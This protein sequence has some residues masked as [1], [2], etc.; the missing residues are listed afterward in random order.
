MNR[1]LPNAAIAVV[2][3]LLVAACVTV[4]ISERRVASRG[5][6]AA[7][8]V[9]VGKP[10]VSTPLF[11]MRRIPE[12]VSMPLVSRGLRDSLRAFDSQLPPSSCLIVE[13][14]G[15]TMIEHAPDAAL[16]PASNMKVLTAAVA[17]DVL[18][19]DRTFT[20]RVYGELS[21][22]TVR[23]LTLVGG[24]DPLLATP[25]YREASKTFTYYA[26]TPWTA[27]ESLATQLKD[28]GVE[29]VVGDISGDG[30]RYDSSDR[31]PGGSVSPI[32]GLVVDDT[33]TSYY[34]DS[35]ERST[36]PTRRSVEL[37]R[38]AL[39]RAGIVTTAGTRS[40]PL[41]PGATEIVHV[42]SQPLTAIVANMLTRSD[43][44][45]AEMLLREIALARAKPA[46]RA[47]GAEAVLDVVASWGVPRVGVQVRDGSGLDREN[48]L[49]CRALV[50][51][52]RHVGPTSALAQGLAVPGRPGTLTDKLESCPVRAAIRAKTGS[53]SGVRALSGFEQVG[54]DHVVMFSAILNALPTGSE[55]A[56][57]AKT[58]SALCTTFREFP[59]VVDVAAFGPTPVN[60]L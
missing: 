55:S 38:T 20:T 1:R 3:L 30:D 33:I 8:G 16:I 35:N 13:A 39:N 60:T 42:D 57:A 40:A 14:D 49:T 54:D 9:A 6:P 59:G 51:T 2:G 7:D 50:A 10:R 27:F 45:T 52:L 53:L 5:N 34:P 37:F 29:R 21:D 47:G 48:K 17:L 23:N 43:N 44:D 25:A 32:G 18:G 22:G 36:D 28:I 26:D 19:P 58:L 12:I 4:G 24:G 15:E 56:Q 11:S 31:G 46:T 41:E